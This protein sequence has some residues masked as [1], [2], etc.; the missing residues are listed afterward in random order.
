[1]TIRPIITLPNGTQVIPTASTRDAYTSRD[2]VHVSGGPYHAD[3][4]RRVFKDET[5]YLDAHEWARQA[6]IPPVSPEDLGRLI[7]EDWHRTL[8]R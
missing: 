4:T 1:M 2:V 6:D 5:A 7:S 3:L 8:G